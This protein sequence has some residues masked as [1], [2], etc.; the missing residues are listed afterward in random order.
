M[1]DNDAKEADEASRREPANDDEN[2]LKLLLA[3]D[4]SSPLEVLAEDALSPSE[5]REIFEVWIRDLTASQQDANTRKTRASIEEAI[6]K[7]DADAAR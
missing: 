6:A 7:L 4:F 2:H 3:G 1:N 5:K